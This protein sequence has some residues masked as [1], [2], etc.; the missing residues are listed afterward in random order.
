LGIAPTL[1]HANTGISPVVSHP[2]AYSRINTDIWTNGGAKM[3]PSIFGIKEPSN[4]LDLKH[5][6]SQEG[7]LTQVWAAMDQPQATSGSYVRPHWWLFA[8]PM[9]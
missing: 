3:L 5:A 8:R 9:I 7:A 1:H 4:Q 6:I 2:G